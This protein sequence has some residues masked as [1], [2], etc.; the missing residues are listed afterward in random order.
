MAGS[1]PFPH[2]LPESAKCIVGFGKYDGKTNVVAS[3]R[4]VIH[5]LMHNFRFSVAVESAVIGKEEFS[6]CV[7]NTVHALTF[8]FAFCRLRLSRT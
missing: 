8:V 2:I 4:E 3:S 7:Q 5:A 1:S 6:Q